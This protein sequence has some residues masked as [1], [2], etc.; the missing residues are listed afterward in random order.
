MIIGVDITGND[1]RTDLENLVVGT[2]TNM[3]KKN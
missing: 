1:I 2:E 3:T